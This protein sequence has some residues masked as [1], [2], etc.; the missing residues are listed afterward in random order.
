[1]FV[2]IVKGTKELAEALTVI[3]RQL[4]LSPQVA[5]ALDP[6][7]HLDIED[8]DIELLSLLA[9]GKSQEEISQYLKRHHISPSSLRTIEKRLNKLRIQFKAKN[10]IH[11]VAQAKDL[12]L[13]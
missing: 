13:I 11:L 3:P 6:N 9:K 7:Q 10:V 12:G 4:Y 5:N 8:F 1:M 2:K